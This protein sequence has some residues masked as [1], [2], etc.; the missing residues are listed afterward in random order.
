[1]ET[2]LVCFLNQKVN[3][4]HNYNTLQQLYRKLEFPS[5]HPIPPQSN[6]L[7]TLSNSFLNSYAGVYI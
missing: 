7:Y 6:L 2:L 5:I 4:T 3:S 1:M